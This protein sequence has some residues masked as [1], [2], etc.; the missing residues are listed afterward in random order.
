MQ[1]E[2]PAIVANSSIFV[3]SA[4]STADARVLRLSSMPKK[5]RIAFNFRHHKDQTHGSIA[6]LRS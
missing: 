4:P 2:L 6:S 3:T 5:L 1:A